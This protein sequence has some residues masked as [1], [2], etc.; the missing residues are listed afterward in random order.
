MNWNN[1]GLKL[2]SSLKFSIVIVISWLGS[3]LS[4]QNL[5]QPLPPLITIEESSTVEVLPDEVIIV[6]DITK[7]N[8]ISTV[9]NINEAFLFAKEDMDIKFIDNK[10]L[11]HTLAQLKLNASEVMFC[12][13]FVVTVKD[14]ELLNKIYLELVKRGFTDIANV[15]FRHKH[16]ETYTSQLRSQAFLEAKKKAAEY[17]AMAGVEL[18]RLYSLT[19]KG[20]NLHNWYEEG[21]VKHS[22]M[23]NEKYL[24]NPGKIT[25]SLQIEASFVIM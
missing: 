12:K 8:A 18:G 25:V 21:E 15:Y 20:S 6:V 10:G 22:M 24:L 16:L 23:L 14:I 4:A 13:S 3:A 2:F 17:A 7:A 1:K 5:C 11:E 19:D 9:S